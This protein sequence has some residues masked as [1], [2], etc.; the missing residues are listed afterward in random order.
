VPNNPF[1]VARGLVERR[2]ENPMNLGQIRAVYDRRAP[3]YDRTIGF[4]ER[5]LLGDLRRAFAAELR[6]QTLEVAIGSG[7]NLPFY[8]PTI[9]RAV[10]IDLSAGMLAEARA[11]AGDLHLAIDLAQMDA[12]RL[13][14]ADASFDTVGVSLALCT[15]PDPA[16]ALAE[17]ARVCRPDGR[18]VL[19]EHVRSPVWPVFALERLVWP[20]QERL[21]GCHLTR[22]TID[23]A[24]RLGFTIESEWRR[25]CGV[26]RL[27]VARPPGNF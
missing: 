18:V 15:V 9:G 17:I 25:L 19:L 4:G 27:V 13:A 11:R 8:P 21:I 5:V 2:E 7:L 14:F 24:R 23:T 26:V 1:G 22:D 10:G 3:S 20:L 6:G 16:A 12:Q